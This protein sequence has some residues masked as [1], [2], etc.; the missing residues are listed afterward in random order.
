MDGGTWEKTAFSASTDEETDFEEQEQPLHGL[1]RNESGYSTTSVNGSSASR[2]VKRE[3]SSPPVRE[4]VFPP[5]P[6]TDCESQLF[7]MLS[8]RVQKWKILGRYLG[9]EDETLDR[10][11]VEN[12]FRIERC[13]K[14]LDTWKKLFRSD[15]TYRRLEEGLRNVMREDIL[16]DIGHFIPCCHDNNEEPLNH[17][18]DVT[19]KENPNLHSIRDEFQQQKNNGMKRAYVTLEYHSD[20]ALHRDALCFIA[21]SLDDLRVLEDLCKFAGSRGQREVFVSLRYLDH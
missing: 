17:T 19:S 14:M 5:V 15:A 9:L 3:A 8:H 10:I 20:E 1:T 13:Y 7:E 12:Q 2:A 16:L 18:V 11:E 6:I 4:V 21:P